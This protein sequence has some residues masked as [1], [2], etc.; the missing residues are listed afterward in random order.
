[1]PAALRQRPIALMPSVFAAT[2]S[3]RLSMGTVPR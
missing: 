1:M 2:G 3:D